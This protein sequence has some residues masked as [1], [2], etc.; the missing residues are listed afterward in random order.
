[1][2]CVKYKMQNPECYLVTTQTIEWQNTGPEFYTNKLDD[3]Y[4]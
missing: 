3:E 4:V 2:Q 1:M